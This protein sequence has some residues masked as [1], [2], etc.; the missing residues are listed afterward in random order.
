MT[1]H[2]ASGEDHPNEEVITQTVDPT[3]EWPQKGT[4]THENSDKL[5]R[6]WTFPFVVIFRVFRGYL[7]SAARFAFSL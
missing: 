3:T 4:K 5:A 1:G 6:T 2:S 7:L